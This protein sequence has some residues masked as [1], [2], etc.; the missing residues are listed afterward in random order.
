MNYVDKPAGIKKLRKT[1]DALTRFYAL[2]ID[3]HYK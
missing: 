1:R 2:E 3:E